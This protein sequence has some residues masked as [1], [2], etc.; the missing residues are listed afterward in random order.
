MVKPLTPAANCFSTRKRLALEEFIR[1]KLGIVIQEH[2]I[3]NLIKTAKEACKEYQFNSFDDYVDNILKSSVERNLVK[4]LVAGITVGESYFFRDSSQMSFLETEFFPKLLRQKNS[5]DRSFRVWSAAASKGQE[6]YSIAMMLDRL[7]S[8]NERKNC[9]LI[10]TDINTESLAC[11][12]K[13]EYNEWSLRTAALELKQTYFAKHGPLYQLCPEIKSMARFSYL[14]LATDSFPSFLMDIHSLDLILCRNVF[15]YLHQDAV[16]E[17]LAKFVDS[18]SPGGILL[19]GTSDLV[20]N[21]VKGLETI[22]RD[23]LTYYQKSDKLDPQNYSD[24]FEK[25]IINENLAV[26]PLITKNNENSLQENSTAKNAIEVL[27]QDIKSMRETPL[28]L[29]RVSTNSQPSSQPKQ[30]FCVNQKVAFKSLADIE[31][32]SSDLVNSSAWDEVVDFVNQ[33]SGDHNESFSLLMD[34]ATAYGNLGKYQEAIATCNKAIE[35]N[36]TDKRAY[37]LLGL[38]LMEAGETV[39]AEAALKKTLFLDSNFLEAH[40]QLGILLIHQGNLKGGIKRL[41]NAQTL[42][43]N[44]EPSKVLHN[45]QEMTYGRIAEVLTKEIELYEKAI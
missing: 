9:H 24:K 39:S 42:A 20:D 43:M 17:I 31:Q 41:K 38:A 40:Y 14:N 34:L 11:A 8:P 25:K 16:K 33:Y 45:A 2:Q 28:A 15:I 19:L 10:G 13:A 26:K 3:S 4:H 23:D 36:S 21:H 12:I 5:V 29:E 7:L 37:F 35:V 44:G 6:L 27:S 22:S 18:L 1:E 32:N 30:T